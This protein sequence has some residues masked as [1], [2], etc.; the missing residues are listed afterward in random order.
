MHA[1]LWWKYQ[2]ERDHC[3]D[4]DIHGRILKCISEKQGRRNELHSSEPG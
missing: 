2:K 3:E 4:L 1:E